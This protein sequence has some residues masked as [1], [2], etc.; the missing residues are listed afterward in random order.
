MRKA[1]GS[2]LRMKTAEAAVLT[3]V[4]L[5][6]ADDASVSLKLEEEVLLSAALRMEEEAR[7]SVALGIEKEASLSVELRRRCCTCHYGKRTVRC[8]L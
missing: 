1:A 7:L 5:D 8:Y 6:E 4:R 3:S 2:S